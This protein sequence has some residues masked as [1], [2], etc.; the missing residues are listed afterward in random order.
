MIDKDR[1]LCLM[2]ELGCRAY[3][4]SDAFYQYGVFTLTEEPYSGVQQEWEACCAE[5]V[6]RMPDGER[7]Y[8]KCME[9]AVYWVCLANNGMT[10]SKSVYCEYHRPRIK[11][12]Q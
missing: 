7:L 8:A 9:P 4:Y 12:A 5:I 1:P 10:E 11:D 2:V 3:S 6:K